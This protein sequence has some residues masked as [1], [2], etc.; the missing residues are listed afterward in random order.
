MSESPCTLVQGDIKAG[1]GRGVD[2]LAT[3]NRN[4]TSNKS[5]QKRHTFEERERR[6]LTFAAV[7]RG[8][9]SHAAYFCAVGEKKYEASYTQSRPW[10]S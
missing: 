2:L 9:C 8:L 7:E 3:E 4:I 5:K 1:E 6:C 10:L